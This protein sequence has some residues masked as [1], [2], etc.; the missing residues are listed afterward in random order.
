MS[1]G[2]ARVAFDQVERK[3]RFERAHPD[4]AIEHRAAPAW[5]W[6]AEWRDSDGTRR[7]IVN[8]ELSGLLDALSDALEGI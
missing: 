4:V 3:Q 1:A 2:K 7:V 5:H 8:H 6:A